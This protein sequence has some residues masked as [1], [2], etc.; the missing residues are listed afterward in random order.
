MADGHDLG[1]REDRQE[2]YGDDGEAEEQRR[3]HLDRGICVPK[4]RY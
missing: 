2:R 3:S 4:L 1:S